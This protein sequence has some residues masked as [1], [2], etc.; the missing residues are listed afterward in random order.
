MVD[1]LP[2]TVERTDLDVIARPSSLASRLARIPFPAWVAL[3]ILA[4]AVVFVPPA[5]YQTRNFFLGWHDV[6]NY[7]RALYNFFEFG[8]FAVSSD[9]AHDFFVEQHFEPFFFLLCVPVRIFGTPGFVALMTA[10][11][12]L[13]AGYVFALG[14]A[15][16]RSRGIGAACAAAYIAN[17]Y[18]FAIAMYYHPE[19]WGILF[20]LAF[21]YHAYVGQ[22]RR[23][24]IALLLALVVKEDM[25]IYAAVV[26]LFAARRDH[27]K[28]TIAFA[29]AAVGY[30]VVAVLMIGGWLYPSARYFNSFYESTGH[31][32]TKLQIASRLAGR[33]HE[34]LPLLFTG[35]GLRYQLSFLFIGVLSGWRYVLACGV[36]LLWLTYPGGRPRSDFSLYYSYAAMLASIVILPFALANL[37][38]ICS[39]SPFGRERLGRWAVATAVALMLA[40]DIVMHLPGH[41]P[42]PIERSIDP[43]WVFGHSPGVN[44]PV[45]RAVIARVLPRDEGS[46]LAQFYTL[47]SLPQRRE[48]YVTYYDMD[49]FLGRRFSPKYVLLDL[50]ADD[51]Y[52]PRADLQK[53][54]SILRGGD[55]YRSLYDHDGVLLYRHR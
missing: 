52:I 26:A 11:I 20:L 51:P 21:A 9:G 33:W 24:W 32:L 34:F 42:A 27:L 23:A 4:A 54:V 49:A 6:G 41:V 37:R 10:A 48:M 31:P 8:R 14:T 53:A 22:I 43:R 12:V 38:A 17:P 19:A 36:A 39:K 35:P 16:G 45:M 47:P 46:I 29:A 55:E 3:S 13:A 40:T 18:T 30:Y 50:G 5:V 7:T 25:W 28:R 1:V 2:G 44:V 15:I